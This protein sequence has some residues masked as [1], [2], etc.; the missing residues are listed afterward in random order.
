MGDQRTLMGG[1][2]IA[3]VT[4]GTLLAVSRA[5]ARRRAARFYDHT[6]PRSGA[7]R[8]G[9]CYVGSPTVWHRAEA[10]QTFH[11]ASLEAVQE[12]LPSDDLYPV[13]FRRD[14]AAIVV[15]AFRYGEIT[16]PRHR[17]AGRA[18]VRRGHGRRPRDPAP[19]TADGAARGTPTR[20]THDRRLRA[21]TTGHA[22]CC[23]GWWPD[24][25]GL[26]Q[27]RR[28]H[29]VRGLHR[30]PALLSVRGGH[31]ILTQTVWPAGRPS[32]RGGSTVLYSAFEG[33]LLALEVP[34]SGIVRQRRGAGGGRLELGDH[35]V[36]DE[37]RPLEINPEPFL[38]RRATELRL[39]MTYGHAVGAARQYL[40]YIGE[41]RDFGRYVVATRTRR[42]STCTP[43]TQRRLVWPRRSR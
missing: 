20:G 22:S 19:G 37:L 41:D 39:A 2:A 29:G 28:R 38:T 32:V 25:L 24:G 11:T 16:F 14:R 31:E 4:A 8:F 5:V 1:L 17:R 15:S 3:G 13:R 7:V 30:D 33:E 40:G 21:A 34:M 12:C 42:P 43:R 9:A 26:S 6:G 27:V 35:Q 10:S 18:P 23:P 36:A